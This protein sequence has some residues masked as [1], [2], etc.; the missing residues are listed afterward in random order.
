M[1]HQIAEIKIKR[2]PVDIIYRIN[3][4]NLELDLAHECKLNADLA[5]CFETLERATV[6]VLRNFSQAVCLRQ[7]TKSLNPERT[8]NKKELYS[9]P[10]EIKKGKHNQKRYNRCRCFRSLQAS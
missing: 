5:F 10:S 8:K 7:I 3:I 9:I 2:K 6:A 1:C 4:F